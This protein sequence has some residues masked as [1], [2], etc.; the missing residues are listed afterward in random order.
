MD[1]V[2][3]LDFAVGV[4][5]SPN[6]ASV[7]A[8]SD[9]GD[10]VA[11]FNR[12]PLTGHLT[13]YDVYDW[14]DGIECLYGPRHPAVSAD[15]ANVYVPSFFGDSIVVFGRDPVTGLLTHVECVTDDTGGVDGIARIKQVSV[16]PDGEHVY[17]ASLWDD[18]VAVF[19][20]GGAAGALTQVGLV[21]N[22]TGGIRSLNHASAVALPS[23]GTS[24]IVTSSADSGGGLTA[25]DRDPSTGGLTLNDAELSAPGLT[26]AVGVVAVAPGCV[27]VSGDS[28]NGVQALAPIESGGRVAP[29]GAW[30]FSPPLY[31]PE[32]TRAVTSL[33]GSGQL[34]VAAHDS[35]EIAPRR[36]LEGAV[37]NSTSAWTMYVNG[38]G[39]VQGL[40]GPQHVALS[41]EGSHLY[42]AS[43]IDDA[44]TV[45]SRDPLQGDLTFV[46]AVFDGDAGVDGLDGAYW[47]EISRDGQHVYVAGYVDDAVAVFTRHPTTGVLTF[48]S[49]VRDGIGG[50]DGLNGANSLAITP[51][52]HH[53]YA[54]G[55]IDD[56]V[57]VFQRSAA[58]GGLLYLGLVRDGVGG[59]D[60]L[61][62]ARA[63][64]VSPLG[65]QVYAV[66][67]FDH[68]LA[69][70]SRD[71]L[72]GN[73]T[74]VGIHRDGIADVDG[75]AGA[76]GVAVSPN[77]AQVFV[78]GY[79]DDAIATFT[80][81]SLLI[82]ID[83]FESGDVG[84][85]D[86]VIGQL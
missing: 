29:L 72:S 80:R 85:W 74:Q 73:L 31:Q 79:S 76:N 23:D 78:T 12:H 14:R 37:S 44:V 66:G 70:F 25:F 43:E 49:V 40:T 53:L 38:A 75:L 28:A 5:V 82:F 33:W 62:G 68:A 26:G 10:A 32:G 55:R 8:T 18:A 9:G 30:M 39:G 41:P 61:N 3:G 81:F 58:T 15:G 86:G 46:Q 59:V 16:S 52:G 57:A 35:D 56:A 69:V 1:G 83:G 50:V 22:G 6:G 7:Y 47:I 60:G 48:H 67:Q 24:V 4:T 36:I 51:D 54:A 21:E 13:F 42:V 11:L 17:A 2:D 34:F 45:F 63:V 20:R 19:E 27:Y 64:A 65:D 84:G 77:G 71:A